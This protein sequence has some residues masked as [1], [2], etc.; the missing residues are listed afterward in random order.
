M[1]V[2]VGGMAAD[3]LHRVVQDGEVAQ[4]QEVHLQQSQ[5]LQ[6]GHGVLGDH[7]LVVFGQGNVGVHRVAGDD[8]PGSVGGGVA[9]HALQAFGGVDDLL[10]GGVT[11]VHL[12]QGLGQGQGGGQGHVQGVGHLLGDG[13]HLG[14]GDVQGPAHVPDGPLGGHG[15]EGDDLSHVVGPVFLVD[16]VDDLAPAA[17]A[18]VHVD[19]GHGDPFRVQEP[20]K[21][22]GVLHGVHVGDVQAVGHHGPGGGAPARPHGNVVGL[23]VADEVGDNEEI[24]HKAHLPDHVHL[25]G[26]LFFIFLAALGI[27]PGKALAAEG[28]KVGVPVGVARGKLEFW[29]VI[30]PELKV[31]V[32]I[33]RDFGGVFQGLGPVGKE[34]G[35]LLL[36]FQVKLL[37]FKPHPVGV[38]HRLAHLDAHEDVLD[39]GV[40]PGEVV[41]VVGGH[42]GDARLLV[43]G[44][45]ALE[46]LLLLGD[47]M[48]LQF[49]IVAVRAKQVPHGQGVGLGPGV[50]PGQ[51]QPGELA[52]Q[53]GGQGDDPLV[54]PGEQ[55]PVHPGLAVKT[56]REAP[57]DQGGEVPVPLLVPAQED[58]V[59]G[60]VVHLM[61]PV[62]A[63]PGGHIDLA[64]DDGL[65]AL[66]LGCPVKIHRPV[67]DPVVGDGHG[68][69][70]QGLGPGHQAVNPAGAV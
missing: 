16:I 36:G 32:A 43:E 64:A 65:D 54:V 52:G 58:Q 47:A 33:R 10:Y 60:A 53:A 27:A 5:L 6:G 59:I 4:G 57:A 11:L 12:P 26:Q 24:L 69:L 50:V 21:V 28:L 38:L 55:L 63:G 40:L 67:H 15:A 56:L 8:H 25:V 30:D 61:D 23:G 51:Q 7:G 19:V 45:Q 13:V 35:H 31:H 70:P 20:L 46:D 9:G 42:Q 34:G 49:Q 1:Q 62:E 37:G 29:Q 18:E 66:L 17:V 22:Q 44:D 41:G 3:H 68:G 14:V 48:V 39:G 2:K